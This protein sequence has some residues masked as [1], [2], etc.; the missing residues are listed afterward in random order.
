MLTRSS[1]TV[2][3]L[4]HYKGCPHRFSRKRNWDAHCKTN[5]KHQVK[6]Q[7]AKVETDEEADAAR[8]ATAAAIKP[9]KCGTPARGKG[10]WEVDIVYAS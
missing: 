8:N 10:S 5:K 7:F 4:H 9:E 2:P 6:C 3:C 1:W